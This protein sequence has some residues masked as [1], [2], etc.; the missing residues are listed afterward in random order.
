M[1]KEIVTPSPEGELNMELT[2]GQKQYRKYKEKILAYNKKNRSKYTAKWK[3][4]G[5]WIKALERDNYTCVTCGMT[6]EEHKIKWNRTI[7]V[8]HI[9]GQGR[10]SK[11]KNNDLSNL[12]TLCLRCHGLKDYPRIKIP[13]EKAIWQLNMNGERIRFFKSIMDA[14]RFT[15][16]KNK[17][18]VR[19]LKGYRNYTHGYKW[20]YALT[21]THIQGGR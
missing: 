7:T 20:E 8:D 5:N 6:N 15:G 9:D 3:F 4:G 1:G 17:N 18:I 10:N 13:K 12:Q 21:P 14:Q 2:E 16:I 19:V 11:V